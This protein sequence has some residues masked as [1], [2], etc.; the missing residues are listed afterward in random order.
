M[1]KE[2]IEYE[3]NHWCYF[4]PGFGNQK[5]NKTQFLFWFRACEGDRWANLNRAD[6][7]KCHKERYRE[8]GARGPGWKASGNASQRSWCLYWVLKGDWDQRERESAEGREG[9]AEQSTVVR[10]DIEESLGLLAESEKEG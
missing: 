8:I 6:F 5:V 3:L 9:P 4:V 10:G 1:G 7:D 2:A